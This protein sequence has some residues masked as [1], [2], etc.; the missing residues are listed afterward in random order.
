MGGRV[1]DLDNEVVWKISKPDWGRF[2]G[3]NDDVKVAKLSEPPRRST[4]KFLVLPWQVHV[5]R[6]FL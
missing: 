3:D 4:K 6:Y 5:L 2:G 1:P